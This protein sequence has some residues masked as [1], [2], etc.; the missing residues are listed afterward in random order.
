MQMSEPD[1][2][3]DLLEEDHLDAVSEGNSESQK[4]ALNDKQRKRLEY[5]YEMYESEYQ[6]EQAEIWKRSGGKEHLAEYYKKAGA[7]GIA[8]KISGAEKRDEYSLLAE[9]GEPPA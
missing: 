2:L 7:I 4:D 9:I 6:G 5:A 8:D 1:E 3:R